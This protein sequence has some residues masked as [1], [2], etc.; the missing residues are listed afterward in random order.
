MIGTHVAKAWPFLGGRPLCGSGQINRSA[1][2]WDMSP[3][4][5]VPLFFRIV[6]L[7]TYEVV[8]GVEGR[9]LELYTIDGLPRTRGIDANTT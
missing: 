7:N 2:C 6:A 4:P 9:S 5:L 3:L 8:V 1:E